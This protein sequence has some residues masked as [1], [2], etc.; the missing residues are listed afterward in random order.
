V[1]SPAIPSKDRE[2]L[3]L[4]HFIHEEVLAGMMPFS[5]NS[6]RHEIHETVLAGKQHSGGSQRKQSTT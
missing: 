3:N 4:N 1:T 5:I 6:Q 2:A